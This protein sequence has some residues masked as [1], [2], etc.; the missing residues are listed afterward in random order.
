MAEEKNNFTTDTQKNRYLTFK[1]GEEYYAIE[2]K[3]VKEIVIMTMQITDIPETAEYFR[4][5]INLRGKIIPVVDMRKRF[6]MPNIEY[7]EKTCIIVV[8]VAGL[9]TG[10]IVERV[11]EVLDI[12][13]SNVTPAPKFGRRGDASYISGIGRVGDKVKIVLDV[14]KLLTSEEIEDMKGMADK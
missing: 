10:F 7:D 3:H 1:I 8:S 9:D 13:S 5:V 11:A 4:G 12:P 6:H 14:D 2:I